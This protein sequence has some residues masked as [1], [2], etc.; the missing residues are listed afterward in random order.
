M[1]ATAVVATA[2]VMAMCACVASAMCDQ[3]GVRKCGIEF[4]NCTANS[5]GPTPQNVTCECYRTLGSC[6]DKYDCYS[7]G[8]YYM[9][10]YTCISYEHGVCGTGVCGSGASLS[11]P[12]AV[13]LV[14]AAAVLH[15]LLR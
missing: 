15:L 10:H 9:F 11:R 6:L 7:D 2:A 3:W 1:R 5:T 4:A 8:P 13:V 14:A 12:L